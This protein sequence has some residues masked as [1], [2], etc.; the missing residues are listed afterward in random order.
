MHDIGG[1]IATV[2]EIVGG[3]ELG[4]RGAYRRWAWQNPRKS[5][6]LGLNPYGCADAANI[7]YTIGGFP[8]DPRERRGWVSTLR[9]LQDPESGFFREATHHEIHTTAHCIA[10]L[11]LFDAPPAHPLKGLSRYR[12]AG[13]MESFL[14]RL[15][16]R[17][18]P[19]RES[20]KG[21][22]LFAAMVLA[23]EVSAEWQDRY[24]AWLWENADPVSGFLRKACISPVGDP[25]SRFPH[26][27]GTFHYLFNQEYARRPLRYPQALV[28]T[29]LDLFRH[30]PYPLA[31]SVGFAEIDWVFCLTRSLR[32][33]GHRHGEC[34]AALAAFVR[35]YVPFL[36]GLD[37]GTHEGLND[38][39]LLF[40]TL[41]CLA[42]LQAVLPG[43]IR[44]ERPL[45]L[46]LD[47][48]P[49]I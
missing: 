15:D 33:C 13:A 46:V 20:H 10:A 27:A 11:E 1:F 25:P 37:P 45:K 22:G 48:R 41:C 9:S 43:Q 29:C 16:W 36:L 14:E 21:A 24:F 5:R 44:T 2:R 19:W 47:R 18:D 8:Q 49:F 12:D 40:G 32:Q 28:D 39:H 35:R 31:D 6:D 7:L 17:R 26:L 4:R 34:H 3:H 38:L 42:E 23:G 30:G